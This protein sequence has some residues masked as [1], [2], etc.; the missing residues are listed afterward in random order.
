MAS[1]EREQTRVAL[2][3][4]NV[5]GIERTSVEFDPGV[6]ILVG[7]NATH[8]TSLL[9]AIMAGLGS[10]RASL[11]GD[12]DEGGVTLRIGDETYTR[13]L[14]RQRDGVAFDGD[15]YLDDPEL[16]D[17]FAFLLESNEARR[18][19]ALG[20][21]LREI[22]MEPV[23][24][25]SIQAD[26]ERLEAEK[27]EVE[28]EVSDLES[29]KSE[30]P[31][32]ERERTRLESEIAETRERLE[33]KRAE[34]DEADASELQAEQSELEA[35][36]ADLQQVQSSLE[37]TEFR[38]DSQRESLETLE[39]E[40]ESLED[41]RDDLAD[42][43]PED[44][45]SVR[46]E[47]DRLQERKRTL[48]SELTKLQSVIQFNEGMLDGTSRDIAAALRGQDGAEGSV[49]DQLL[50]TSE[51]VVCWTCGTEVDPDRIERTLERLRDLRESKYGEQSDVASRLDEL[52]E[53]KSDIESKQRRRE[54]VDTRIDEA[55]AEIDERTGKIETLEAEREELQDEIETLEDEIEALEQKDRSAV[56]ATHKR[57][58]ELEIELDRLETERDR[59]ASNIEEIESRTAEIDALEDRKADIRSELTD[60]RTRIDRI[61]EQAVA[62]FNDH[63][64]T[65]LDILNYANIDRI[66]V[67]RTEREVREGRRT[68]SETAFDLHVVR[69][70]DDGVTYEDDFEHLSESEREVT[71]LVFALAG[72]L[73][74][75]VYEEVPFILLDSLEAIDSNR[76]AKLVEYIEE[77]VDYLVVALLPEDATALDDAYRRVTE[78]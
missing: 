49:T 10:R 46:A 48:D 34:F 24:A 45:E 15:P 13:T 72:Y 42:V 32:L 59:V 78:I 44:V 39:S 69:S 31:D 62:E 52:K 41:R 53:R 58:N 65:V 18:T 36:M 16:A 35:K 14:H 43:D 19:V 22:I 25:E 3:A 70:T 57:V 66:W 54:R 38:L 9:Q 76:I 11:K 71:G 37:Q 74:H 40:L 17:L 6:T 77:Y 4:E 61:E 63:M 64:D 21:D 30:L 50:E 8:R 56:L 2:E 67:E 75:E 23:D 73:A 7:R 5:G 33:A 27:R 60:R 1:V 20:G 51:S 26:I 55:R 12:A 68:V 28:E 29:L 47:I